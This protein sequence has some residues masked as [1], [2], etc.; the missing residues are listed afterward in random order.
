[1]LFLPTLI[2]D[3]EGSFMVDR[4]V[5]I[6]AATARHVQQLAAN[7]VFRQRPL[8]VAQAQS[9]TTES[10]LQNIHCFR[11]HNVTEQNPAQ[12]GK[13]LSACCAAQFSLKLSQHFLGK[14]QSHAEGLCEAN[15]IGTCRMR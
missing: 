8:A 14:K 9:F 15:T 3:T 13:R 7:P 4:V 5:D 12:K 2:T 6:A 11:V 1:M 10:I